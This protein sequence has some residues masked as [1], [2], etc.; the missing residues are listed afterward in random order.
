MTPDVCIGVAV[1]LAYAVT[2]AASRRW[3]GVAARQ[4]AAVGRV[5]WWWGGGA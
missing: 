5:S 1:L 3:R 2:L 4:D